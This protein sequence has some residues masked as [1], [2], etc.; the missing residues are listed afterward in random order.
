MTNTVAIKDMTVDQLHREIAQVRRA[1]EIN[2]LDATAQIVALSEELFFKETV[3]RW[4]GN[5]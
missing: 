5:C 2:A 3:A 1:A 4:G